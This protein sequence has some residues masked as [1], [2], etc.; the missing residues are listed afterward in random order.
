MVCVEPSII[1]EIVIDT[2]MLS[3]CPFAELELVQLMEDRRG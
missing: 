2:P 3:E 1:R